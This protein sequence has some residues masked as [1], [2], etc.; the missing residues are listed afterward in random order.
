M[1]KN[2]KHIPLEKLIGKFNKLKSSQTINTNNQ[3]VKMAKSQLNLD[4]IPLFDENAF[5]IN[6]FVAAYAM[7][8][9]FGTTEADQEFIVHAIISKLREAQARICLRSELKT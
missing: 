1:S 6:P 3:I 9:K 2:S 5:T 4:V 7:Y 8:T